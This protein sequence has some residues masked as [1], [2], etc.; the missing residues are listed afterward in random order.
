MRYESTPMDLL[1]QQSKVGAT[2]WAQ[3][4][5]QAK[6]YVETRSVTQL[7]VA[8][9]RVYSLHTVMLTIMTA[10]VSG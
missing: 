2:W 9:Y 7:L 4:V 1:Y 8:Y 5:F 6:T 10:V 3:H